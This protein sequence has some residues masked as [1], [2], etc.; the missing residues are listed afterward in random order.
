MTM[1]D[2]MK[3]KVDCKKFLNQ[4]GQ[5]IFEMILFLPFLLFLYTIYYT[6]GN[7]I[8]SSIN[9]Q[10]AV[11]GYFYTLIKGNSYLVT[12]NELRNQ[13]NNG[14]GR[15]GFNGIGWAD[16][17]KGQKNPIA[18]CFKFSSLLKN[19]STEEC[20]SPVREEPSS[21]RFIRLYTYY[22]VCGPTYIF[23][24]ATSASIIDPHYQGQSGTESC[25]TSSN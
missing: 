7:A 2:E 1:A 19:G 10:K 9:Q 16:S 8:S 14:I 6:A 5:A 12:T 18:P 4:K 21:S 25:I 23:D 24:N 15:V 20:E 22:G 3:L 13:R 11:R 17:M